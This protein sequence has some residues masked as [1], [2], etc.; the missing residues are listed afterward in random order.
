MSE[1]LGDEEGGISGLS[2]KN[3]QDEVSNAMFFNNNLIFQGHRVQ[4]HL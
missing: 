3:N 4:G 2:W 1:T